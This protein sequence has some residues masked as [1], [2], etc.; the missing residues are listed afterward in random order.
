M[1]H[2]THNSFDCP[3]FMGVNW[4]QPQQG[5]S[6]A[7]ELKPNLLDQGNLLSDNYWMRFLFIFEN[8]KIGSWGYIHLLPDLAKQSQNFDLCFACIDLLSVASSGTILNEICSF[9][10]HADFDVR[11]SAYMAAARSCSLSFIEPLLEARS[12][13]L[14]TEQGMIQ[15]SLTRLLEPNPGIIC[16]PY[17]LSETEYEKVVW[18]TKTHIENK[19]GEGVPVFRGEMLS[20]ELIINRIKET[21]ENHRI[22]EY[23]AVLDFDLHL[24]EAMTGTPCEGLFDDEDNPLPLSIRAT[25]ENFEK[26]GHLSKFRRGQRYFF[27]HS[28]AGDNPIID[29]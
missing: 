7:F 22:Q 26:E 27:G 15:S 24:F 18:N 4:L 25:I 9:F 23:W 29:Q 10:S 2:M 19:I 12:K 21:T 14:S 13:H 16:E 3:N 11:L 17:G 28:V 8:A 5:Y 20:L 6:Y 1:T